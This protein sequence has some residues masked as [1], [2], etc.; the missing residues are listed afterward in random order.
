MNGGQLI[1]LN[2]GKYYARED[3]LAIGAGFFVKGL[4]YSAQT[5]ALLVG[6]PNAAFFTSA[7]YGQNI[8]CEETV[9]IGDVSYLF[10][11]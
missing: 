3:G 11:T 5:K 4:E 10:R 1:A 7:L 9:M 6:K 8:S 2:A